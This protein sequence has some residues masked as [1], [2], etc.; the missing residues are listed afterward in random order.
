MRC[1]KKVS[2]HDLPPWSARSLQRAPLGGSDDLVLEALEE[3]LPAAAGA[4]RLIAVVPDGGLAAANAVVRGAKLRNG[5]SAR[6]RAYENLAQA[7]TAEVA[8]EL[9][10]KGHLVR[11]LHEENGNDRSFV[12]YTFD[13]PIRFP[14]P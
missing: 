11:N 9:S 1:T 12:P 13:R 7:V 8:V 10:S 2:G 6:A 3:E 5:R 4:E 14:Y